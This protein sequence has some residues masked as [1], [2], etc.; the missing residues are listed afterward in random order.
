[1]TPGSARANPFTTAVTVFCVTEVYRVSCW[2]VSEF[3]E[4]LFEG[5]EEL[6]AAAPAARR[7]GNRAPRARGNLITASARV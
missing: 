5:A 4:A 3:D 1:L 7:I 2:E 6:Q